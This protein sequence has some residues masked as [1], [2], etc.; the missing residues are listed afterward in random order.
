MPRQLR[1]GDRVAG[2]RQAVGDVAQ[3]DRR[4]AQAVDEQEARL[5][6]FMED[7]AI[8]CGLFGGVVGLD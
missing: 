3:L 2:A 5:A 4:A 8:F 7:A 6:A 1:T